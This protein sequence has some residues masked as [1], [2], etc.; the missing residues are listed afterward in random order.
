M[1]SMTF[2]HCIISAFVIITSG[3]V[4][5]NDKPIIPALI[6]LLGMTFVIYCDVITDKFFN[7]STE[8][9]KEFITL[10]LNILGGVLIFTTLT[11]S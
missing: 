5:I 7:N 8:L 11:F 1:Q 2:K 10:A 3:A 4:L 9:T 6:V